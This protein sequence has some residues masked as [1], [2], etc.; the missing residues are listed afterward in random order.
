MQTETSIKDQNFKM[1]SIEF[2][3]KNKIPFAYAWYF[4]DNGKKYTII[5]KNNIALSEI[6][7]YKEK[8]RLMYN[9]WCSHLKRKL[10]SEE[11]KTKC[12][13]VFSLYLKYA[14]DIVCIDCDAK[15]IYDPNQ[16]GQILGVP[17]INNSMCW[18]PGNNKGFHIYVRIPNF[19]KSL[20]G[21]NVFGDNF[22]PVDII[23]FTKNVW[24]REDKLFENEITTFDISEIKHL[25]KSNKRKLNEIETESKNEESE[26]D[27]T[28]KSETREFGTMQDKLFTEVLYENMLGK[29]LF[30][31]LPSDYDDWINYGFI[32]VNAQV[33]NI[34]EVWLAVCQQLN[35][36]G[37]SSKS[38]RLEKL[39]QLQNSAKSKNPI[40]FR[41]LLTIL[42]KIMGKEYIPFM[43][44]VNKQFKEK[45]KKVWYEITKEKFEKTHFE[46]KGRVMQIEENFTLHQ[47]Q[48]Q[49]AKQAYAHLNMKI[50][51]NKLFFLDMWHQDPS[52]RVINK[53]VMRPDLPKELDPVKFPKT[54]NSFQ[55]YL[56]ESHDDIR[57]Q[58]TEDELNE[59]K[60][61]SFI[62]WLIWHQLC[63][64]N[65]E[66]YSEVMQTF[67][68][69]LFAPQDIGRYHSC[70]TFYSDTEG[71]GK[72]MITNMFVETI[73]GLNYA[74]KTAKMD[75]I[76]GKYTELAENKIL[77]VIE[78]G[79]KSEAVPFADVAKDWL[80]S[81]TTIVHKKCQ[82]KYVTN[83]CCHLI[84]NTNNK[85]VWKVSETNRRYFISHC[86]ETILRKDYLK[87]V[88]NEIKNLDAVVKFCRVLYT[89]WNREWQCEEY[90]QN[91][92]KSTEIYKEQLRD[93]IS[94]LDMFLKQFIIDEDLQEIHG[95]R[96]KIQPL[97]LYNKF[98]YIII[99]CGIQE[100]D[101]WTNRR[102]GEQL[103]KV[104]GVEQNGYR[105]YTITW[106]TIKKYLIEKH[107]LV[108]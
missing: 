44:E 5:E 54:Y 16:L 107:L 46:F 36:S 100:K 62:C 43:K 17:S 25:L 95:L 49:D 106:T 98:R 38:E 73:I 34:A 21:T 61:G 74:C 18:T 63:N 42:Q 1:D 101:V 96:E 87:D 12:R 90:I 4:F 2:I 6:E 99:S 23:K 93:Q 83:N 68:N 82:S 104:P 7:A 76:F 108:E 22:P 40:T 60:G 71:V 47:W 102:F 8:S 33:E 79:K 69:L 10:T 24:E 91:Q 13:K 30:T 58:L 48:H 26:V 39:Q 35:D 50:G 31:Q 84:C 45:S 85:S 52:K 66:T 105:D 64:E 53:I 75:D 11:K 97:C 20:E 92:Y 94:Q 19:N 9:S 72:S 15:E 77:I 86:K 67:A 81:E 14:E 51:E 65:E 28:I 103:K 80:T 27:F 56:I 78:E 57:V 70:L 55:G 32:L 29:K 89:I 3:V 88:L 41:S 37:N 59:W